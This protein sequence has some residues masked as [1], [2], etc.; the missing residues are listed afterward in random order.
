[1]STKIDKGKKSPKNRK[2]RPQKWDFRLFGDDFSFLVGAIVSPVFAV[3]PKSIFGRFFFFFFFSISGGGPRSIVS[4]VGRL[5]I[6]VNFGASEIY[7][8]N[9]RTPKGGK[10]AKRSPPQK[11]L[12]EGFI[13]LA[14]LQSEVGPKVDSEK[15]EQE[16]KE[17]ERKRKKE[18]ERRKR[19]KERERK[20]ERKRKKRKKERKKERER[21]R[22]KERKKERKR[23]KGTRNEIKKKEKKQKREKKRKKGRGRKKRK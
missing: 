14:R 18:R 5:A 23:K 19:K 11:Q 21:K 3:R 12:A 13:G 7:G 6:L 8:E 1:M 10:G 15:K 20:K 16:K 9:Q 22:K 17:K 4:Q 2:N